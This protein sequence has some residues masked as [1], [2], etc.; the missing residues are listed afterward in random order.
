MMASPTSAV[1]GF[2]TASENDL[3]PAMV[4]EVHV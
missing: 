4:M 3:F 1:E 2:W